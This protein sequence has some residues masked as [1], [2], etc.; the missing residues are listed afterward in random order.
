M[1]SKNLDHRV[2]HAHSYEALS[3][4]SGSQWSDVVSSLAWLASTQ[5]MPSPD[6]IDMD[7]DHQNA[8]ALNDPAVAFH[9]QLHSPRDASTTNSRCSFTSVSALYVDV[10]TPWAITQEVA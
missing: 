4:P 2:T 5:S 10:A 7:E 8:H 1:D 3:H 9:Q 6:V